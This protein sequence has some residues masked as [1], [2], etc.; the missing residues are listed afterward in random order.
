MIGYVLAF[1][2]VIIL[3]ILGSCVVIVPQARSYVIERFGAFRIAWTTG[4]HI[5]VPFIER[6][7]KRVD[8]R[9]QVYDFA[10]QP[11]ITKDNVK[12]MVDTIVFA[13]VIDAKL[14]TYGVANP[15]IAIESLCATT[16]RN[17]MGELDLDGALTSRDIINSKMR[18]IIDE[19][20]DPWG[21]KITR[22][23]LKSINAPPTI[24]EAMERQMQA[25]REK[26][27]KILIAEGAKKSAILEAEGIKESTILRAD[28]ERERRIR[29]AQ[30]EADAIRT[31]QKA[32][33]DG[34]KM[35]K[36]AGADESVIRL[37]SLKAM[38]ELAHGSAN[39]IIIPSDI[40]GTAGIV[41]ALAEIAKS[42]N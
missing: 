39:K 6:V 4:L 38:K 17:I 9:E 2:A 7:A 25:E 11:V 31:V 15:I 28:A 5:K 32:T 18:S 3:L 27:E 19:A 10:P 33:A 16:L 26:R 29:E 42:G 20:T 40:Q 1:V 36:E 41:A 13:Q 12:I 24:Q 37:E 14:Y 30:G 21:V 35:I 8:L 22:V 23:E 34:I